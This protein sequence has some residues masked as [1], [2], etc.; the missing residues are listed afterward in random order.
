MAPIGAGIAAKAAK[1][2]KKA[3]VRL[4]LKNLTISMMS[5]CIADD[6]PLWLVFLVMAWFGVSCLVFRRFYRHGHYRFLERIIEE[7]GAV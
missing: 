1:I 6:S 5:L 3:A 2:V 4:A 7:G